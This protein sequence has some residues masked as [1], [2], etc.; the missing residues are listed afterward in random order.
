MRLIAFLVL[1][2][3]IP[4]LAAAQVRS[5]EVRSP[6]A[7]G[8][9]V[10]DIVKSQI[11]IVV[12]EGFSIQPASLPKPGPA[13]YWLDL[14]QIDLSESHE[15]DAKRIRLN[16][17]Y[18]SFYAALD[19]RALEVPGFPLTVASDREGGTTTAKA[20]V[21]TW[22]INVSPLREVQPP[23]RE[24][25]TEYM[26]PDGRVAALDPAPS[27]N[28]ALAFAGLALLA[29]AGLA[30]DHAWGPFAARH[31]RPFSAA[32]KQLG[33][34]ARR[35]DS[36][37]AYREALLALHRGLDATDGR[38]VLADD[39][40][41]FL[42][43]HPAFGAEQGGLAKFFSASRLA[44]FGRETGA[45]RSAWPLAEAQEIARRLAAAERSA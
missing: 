15:G 36:N 24:D 3:A 21:P 8:Y 37:E 44:F 25:P 42:E 19:A 35:P 17:T 41:G 45:A 13:A 28:A 12:D 33:R 34:L 29:L 26:R 20:D 10:G 5:V 2:L 7:F 27:R 18:Q 6:R 9:F 14:R 23:K 40:G 30:W 16:L 4:N 38:R 31:G 1:L 11:D 32:V 43:R 39:L 22:T